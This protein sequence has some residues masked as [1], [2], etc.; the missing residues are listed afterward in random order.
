ML[1]SGLELKLESDIWLILLDLLG[2]ESRGKLIGL[3]G[4][5]CCLMARYGG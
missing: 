2:V 4:L 1:G 3:V 5:S